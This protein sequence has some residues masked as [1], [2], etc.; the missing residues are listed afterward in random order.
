MADALC[1]LSLIRLNPELQCPVSHPARPQEFCADAWKALDPHWAL[2]ER[3]QDRVQSLAKSAKKVSPATTQ[4]FESWFLE[5]LQESM[6]PTGVNLTRLLDLVDQFNELETKKNAPLLY[7]F[8][9]QFSA[10][11]REK[12]HTLYSFLFHLRSVIAVDWNAHV[13]DAS[14]EAVKV[15]SI[16]DYLPKA[17]YIVN[18]AVLYWN[19]KKLAHPFV[20]GRQSDVKV[21]K[22]LIEPLH[23]AFRASS[24][25]ACHLIDHLPE[26]FLKSLGP[27]EL[28]ETLYLVQMDW[29]LGS[30]AG[31]LFRIREELFGLQNGYE[32][33]FWPDMVSRHSHQAFNLS[34]S[35]QLGE[36]DF[37]PSSRAA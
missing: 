9:L 23:Q 13:D 7:N 27:F 36:S 35:F 16:T 24:H 14:H 10:G 8:G 21:E 15:D 6:T 28:E 4:Q 1:G 2:W 22:L 33:V 3:A 31:L 12:M 26:S 32:K 25:N 37:R 29:L 17:E 19:F 30:D 5:T 18:D 34:L 20:A 11:F